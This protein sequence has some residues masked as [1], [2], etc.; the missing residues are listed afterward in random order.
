MSYI[1]RL[2]DGGGQVEGWVDDNDR[3]TP[4]AWEARE[5]ATLGAALE[6]KARMAT[7]LGVP[8]E[9]G[10]GELEVIEVPAT[11]VAGYQVQRLGPIQAGSVLV[12]HVAADRY[13]AQQI[14]QQLVEKVGHDE[15]GL[16]FV[17][18]RD[19]RSPVE[20][21]TSSDLAERGWV[22]VGSPGCCPQCGADEVT[23]DTDRVPA[24]RCGRCG[25]GWTEYHPGRAA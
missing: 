22:F 18:P 2:L 25:H 24:R 14:K 23:V 17:D 8:D 4:V 16:L 10:M 6:G 21:L 5:Y 11:V 1:V 19:S 7:A 12:V 13:V 15:F 3:I 20:L 9:Y